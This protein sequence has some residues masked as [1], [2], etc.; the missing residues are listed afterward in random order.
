MGGYCF[1]KKT[2]GYHYPGASNLNYE[3]IYVFR[4]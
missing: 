4:L 3:K 2:S 1:N